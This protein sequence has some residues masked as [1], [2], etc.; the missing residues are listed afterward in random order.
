MA[1]SLLKYKKHE[2]ALL[3]FEQER[4]IHEFW[5]NKGA[6]RSSVHILL[7]INEIVQRCRKD[8]VSSVLFFHNHPNPDP[9]HYSTAVPSDLDKQL[10]QQWADVLNSSGVNLL[11]FICERGTA[12]EYFRAIAKEF[13]P[14][15][16]YVEDINRVNATSRWR[17]LR[18]HLAHIF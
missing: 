15:R 8:C 3:A 5:T 9:A 10:S 4:V 7:S 16:S 2:W 13:L 1:A 12:H 6:D 18:L 17:N 14:R 11:S